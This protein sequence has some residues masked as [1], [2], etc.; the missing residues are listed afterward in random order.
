MPYR[1]EYQKRKEY[2]RK[3]NAQWRKRNRQYFIEYRKEH[4]EQAKTW[5]KTAK[6]KERFGSV[7]RYEKAIGKNEGYCA[8]CNDKATEVHHTDGQSTRSLS[9]IPR[10]QINNDLSN[11]L[12]VC[13]A[14]HGWLH[15]MKQLN[16]LGRKG[17]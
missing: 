17:K 3:W 12:P 1:E 13:K 16:S 15:R 8:L 10:K 2:Y 7:E 11:L 4:G 6:T 9:P 14:C 5:N